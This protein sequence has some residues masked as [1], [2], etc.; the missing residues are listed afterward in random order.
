MSKPSQEFA[1]F[2]DSNKMRI[3]FQHELP[4]CLTGGW[5][6]TD[7]QIQHPRYKTYLN[8]KSRDK[9]FLALAYHLKGINEQTQ[10][11]DERILYVKAYLGDRSHDEYLKA[12]DLAKGSQQSAILHLDKYGMVGWFFP[13]DP[14]LPMLDKVLDKA[15]AEKYLVEFLLLQQQGSSAIIRDIA[16]NIINYR[17]EIRC[18]YRYDF[19]RLSGNKKAVYGK[20]FVD[21]KGAEIQHRIVT[22]YKHAE[23]NPESFVIPSPLGYDEN[24]NTLWLDGLSGQSLLEHIS[25][26][27]ADRLMA[28]LARHLVDFQDV[29]MTGLAVISEEDMLVEI[30]KKVVKLQ[31][32]FQDLSIR[33]ERLVNQLYCE[34]ANLPLL[35][36]RLSHGDFH[37]QQLLLM[38]ADRIAL[39]DFDEL[40]VASPLMDMANFSAD[41]YSLNLGNGLTEKLINCLYKA[42]KKISDDDLND[43]HFIWH[44]RIQLLTRAYRSY[45]QQ[46]PDLEWL[47]L[48]YL[49]LAETFSLEKH[50]E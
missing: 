43:S 4:D 16:I 21:N 46:K 27:N 29:A 40:T 28:Q 44:I 18:T 36:N 32:V 23:N 14:A 11:A 39:F 37:I 38:K 45:I 31:N 33:F 3:L 1:I 7:C 10:K 5:K 6:L 30:Q 2:M 8:P 34:K 20:T 26:K 15:F 47:V 48:G 13:Y 22:L 24:L 42:Y 35:A 50:A 25:D 41:L 12:R 49:A 19:Q 9:S 17:P